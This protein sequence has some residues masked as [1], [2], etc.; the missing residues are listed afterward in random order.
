VDDVMTILDTLG[1]DRVH[2]LGMSQGGRI[3]LRCAAERPERI[4]SLLL[5]GPGV[6]GID[7]D[8]PDDERIP[9]D[10]YVVLARAGRLEKLR[11]RWRDHPM[12][13]EVSLP[14]DARKLV[15]DMLASWDARDL[16]AHDAAHYRYPPG[17]EA[18]L[19]AFRPPVLIL[20]GERETAARKALAARL[21]G[22]FP[23]AR[24]T[25]LADSGHFSNLAAPD[26]YNAA[27]REFCL[28]A[29]R[30]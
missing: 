10:E 24:E 25:V 3:A 21:I 11:L 19:G 26:A 1:I 27:V 4:R 8:E 22:L 16:V 6:D 15:D 28:A 7:V 17:I 14:D 30:P 12:M 20:T 13:A 9:I 2:L 18:A 5:Q 29:D 23:D